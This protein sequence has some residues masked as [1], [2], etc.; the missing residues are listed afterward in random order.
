MGAFDPLL[1]IYIDTNFSQQ[2]IQQALPAGLN[3]SSL[4]SP[5]QLGPAV[6]AYLRWQ[7]A[8]L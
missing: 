7:L 3:S 8:R 2:Y 6:G 4:S 5:G 1:P